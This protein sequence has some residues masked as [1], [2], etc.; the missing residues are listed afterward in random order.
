MWDEL[1]TPIEE[2][3]EHMHVWALAELEG[4]SLAPISYELVGAARDLSD[5]LG[6]RAEAV[7][8]GK[9][10]E[11]LAEE[12]TWRGADAVYVLEDEGLAQYRTEA[13]AHVVAELVS[14]RRPEI[15]LF[16]ATDIGEDLAPRLA[17]RLET[18]LLSDCSKVEVDQAERVLLGTRPT[19]DGELM[20]TTACPQ[21]RP[22]MATVRP[23]AVEPFPPNTA[24]MGEVERM[25]AS[26]LEGNIRARVVEVVEEVRELS[27]P[28]AKVVVAGGRGV[29]S[30]E[31]FQLLEELARA[32]GASVG[33]SRGAF[34][35]GW[36][37]KEYWIG[38][39][40]GTPVAP[41]LYIACG[42]SG[43]IHHYLGIK[44][45]KF[46]VTINKDPRAPIF[47]FAD[48]GI[49]GDLHEVVPALIEELRAT[50]G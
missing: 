40:G 33:A 48:V 46:I 47:K 25:P 29:G 15:L 34:D 21:K 16:G 22:Q 38:G 36:V 50:S 6:V 8:L 45:A 5:L 19:Y 41:D 2:V 28:R 27:L 37:G 13:Y 1:L 42:I 30:A 9:D 23:G 35:E 11:R 18:G 4:D 17:Q 31:G 3:A 20:V 44:D 26:L 14:E 32:L 49:V 39:A 7:L 24:R 12:L 43:A 10:V